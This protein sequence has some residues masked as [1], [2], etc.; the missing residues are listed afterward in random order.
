MHE[1]AS[2]R[3]E[4]EDRAVD[5]LARLAARGDAAAFDALVRRC[6]R[7]IYRWALIRVVDP[8]EA[9][10]VTQEV[11]IR[12]Y[13]HLRTWEARGRFTTW[14]YGVTRN[15]AASHEARNRTHDRAEAL[16]RE[17][18]R[19]MGTD[20]RLVRRLHAENLMGRVDHLLRELPAR[21][22]EL[23]DLIDVQG[24][25]PAEVAK[26]LNLNQNTVRV[27]LFRARRRIRA[28]VLARDPDLREEADR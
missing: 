8:D 14:L 22:R 28:W 18:G 5:E 1:L 26:M 2:R 10:D 17:A 27:H 21:Q 9:E 4:P 13:R 20:E 24:F 3:V 12:L 11:L 7:R 19:E 6:Y 15:A 25:A 23:F 16:S